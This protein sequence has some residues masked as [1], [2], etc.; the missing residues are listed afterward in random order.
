[1]K[2]TFSQ[3]EGDGVRGLQTEEDASKDNML[4]YTWT[5]SGALISRLHAHIFLQEHA[6]VVLQAT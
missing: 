5:A 4:T 2:P 3:F 6:L 1:M